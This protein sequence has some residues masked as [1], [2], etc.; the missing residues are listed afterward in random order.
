MNKS[1]IYLKLRTWIFISKEML[2]KANINS[3]DVELEFAD[4]ENRIRSETQKNKRKIFNQNSSPLEMRRL[5]SNR[6]C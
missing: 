1:K 6:R 3:E 2:S 5:C 4:H